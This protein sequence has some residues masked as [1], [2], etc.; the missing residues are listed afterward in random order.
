METYNSKSTAAT[1]YERCKPKKVWENIWQTKL[2]ILIPAFFVTS[3]FSI[4]FLSIYMKHELYLFVQSTP[5]RKVNIWAV[6]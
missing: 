4:L 1:L 5:T 3:I 6:L 2:H